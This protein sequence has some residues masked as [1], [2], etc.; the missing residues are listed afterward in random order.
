MK[1]PDFAERADFYRVSERQARRWHSEGVNLDDPKQVAIALI[2]R[3]H[4][5]RAALEAL[6]ELPD[7]D[8]TFSD[9]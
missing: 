2:D 1:T 6:A 4:P 5:S 9:P 8:L 7:E 3:Q